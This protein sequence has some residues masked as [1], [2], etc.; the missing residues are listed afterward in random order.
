ME[1][2]FSGL[3]GAARQIDG[4]RITGRV[5]GVLGLSLAATGLERALGIGARC[6]VQGAKGP[7]L[8]EVVAKPEG[9]A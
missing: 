8:G 4:A 1:T 9:F 7:V 6:T 5:S 3:A 2:A